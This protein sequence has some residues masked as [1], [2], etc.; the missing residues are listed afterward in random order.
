MDA[1]QQPILLIDYPSCILPLPMRLG[2]RRV[3]ARERVLLGLRA[4]RLKLSMC[5]PV[6]ESAPGG[7]HNSEWD[8]A[9][10]V[11]LAHGIDAASREAEM[12]ELLNQPSSICIDPTPTGKKWWQ[13]APFEAGSDASRSR[14]FSRRLAPR[15]KEE[16]HP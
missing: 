14:Y 12:R 9:G 4:G 13:E 11:T 2:S 15:S 10:R 6:R 16:S 8:D 1:P 7:C 5:R 3:K